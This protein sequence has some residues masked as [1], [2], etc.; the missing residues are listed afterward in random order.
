MLIG[1]S[2]PPGQPAPVYSGRLE[3]IAGTCALAGHSTWETQVQ[4]K[5]VYD[6]LKVLFVTLFLVHA[7]QTMRH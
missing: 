5:S 3:Y 6:H 2:C 7:V 4:C 1:V